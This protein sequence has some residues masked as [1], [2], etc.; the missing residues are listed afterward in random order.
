MNKDTKPAAA[1]APETP[2]AEP[3]NVIVSALKN[4]TLLGKALVAAGRVDFRLTQSEADAAV[5]AGLVTID[6]IEL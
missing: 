3:R 4:R 2:A 6:G 5:K 1:A